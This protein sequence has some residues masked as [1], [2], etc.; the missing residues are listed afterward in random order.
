L[1]LSQSGLPQYVMVATHTQIIA[2]FAVHHHLSRFGGVPVVPV[3]ALLI[4]N[5]QPSASI[6]AITSRTFGMGFSLHALAA[7]GRCAL[8]MPH[9]PRAR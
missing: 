9:G 6:P 4:K 7:P 5:R 3:A 2:Q 1:L 8:I